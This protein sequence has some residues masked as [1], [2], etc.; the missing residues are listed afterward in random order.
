MR[1]ST[2]IASIALGTTAL[3]FVAP[4]A[5][6]QADAAVSTASEAALPSGEFIKK[7]KKLKGDWSVVERDGNTYIQFDENFRAARG[8]DLKIFLSPSDVASVTGDTAVDGSLNLGELQS[9][10]GAQEYLVPEGVNLAD[11]S[12]VLVHCEQYAVLW[13]GGDL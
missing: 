3:T 10:K 13:G 2:L 12:S 7:K 4:T 6:A 1:I 5:F 9:T 8:P 11:Y